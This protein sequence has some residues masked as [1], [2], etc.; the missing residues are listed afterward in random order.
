MLLYFLFN[1]V[2]LYLFFCL[3]IVNFKFKDFDVVVK[4]FF[5]CVKFD[6]FNKFV[7]IYLVSFRYFEIWILEIGGS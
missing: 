6:R 7:Y 1:I 4:D 3:G 2:D 5:I